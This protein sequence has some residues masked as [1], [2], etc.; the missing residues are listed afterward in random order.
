MIKRGA[1]DEAIKKLE[2]GLSITFIDIPS[3]HEAAVREKQI[4]DEIWAAI[5]VLKVCEA[6][7]YGTG[8]WNLSNPIIEE[9]AKAILK[10][11]SIA[12]R[13]KL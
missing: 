7:G 1:F 2:K 11:Q 4:N 8:P 3:Q 12:V 10:A 9:L 13:R 5:D 6:I